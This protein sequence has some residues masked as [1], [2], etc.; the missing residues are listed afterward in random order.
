MDTETQRAL[1][2]WSKNPKYE[3][4]NTGQKI[5][6]LVEACGGVLAAAG[7]CVRWGFESVNPELPAGDQETNREWLLRELR[8]LE[9]AIHLV[10]A[11]VT[12]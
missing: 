2:A 12:E 4:K 3:P 8:D 5:G 11:A 7:K 10:R 9:T 6:Y 1:S